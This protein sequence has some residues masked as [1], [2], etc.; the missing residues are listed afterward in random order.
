[1]PRRVPST[2]RVGEVDDGRSSVDAKSRES[3]GFSD[4]SGVGQRTRRFPPPAPSRPT[5]GG[6][7]TKAWERLDRDGGPR[8]RDRR[9]G[10]PLERADQSTNRARLLME[11]LAVLDRGRR[12]RHRQLQRQR[13]KQHDDQAKCGPHED[14]AM[15]ISATAPTAERWSS[16]RARWKRRAH[17]YASGHAAFQRGRV[18]CASRQVSESSLAPFAPSS[19]RGCAARLSWRGSATRGLDPDLRWVRRQP[20][21]VRATVL[22]ASRTVG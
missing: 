10:R 17:G 14:T 7:W 15:T 16:R 6:R 5:D 13:D 1:M 9:S 11:C 2:T 4:G 19:P 3:V 8:A 12:H 18:P 21:R 22:T 20:G